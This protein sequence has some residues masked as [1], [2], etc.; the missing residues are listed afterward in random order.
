ML[1]VQVTALGAHRALCPRCA[2]TVR[3]VGPSSPM[4]KVAAVTTVFPYTRLLR[5]LISPKTQIMS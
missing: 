3:K 4:A 1:P 5:F 2:R